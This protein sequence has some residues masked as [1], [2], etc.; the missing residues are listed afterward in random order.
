MSISGTINTTMTL[1]DTIHSLTANIKGGAGKLSFQDYYPEPLKLNSLGLQLSADVTGKSL[2]I[3]S[4]DILFGQ[5]ASPLKLHLTATAQMLENAVAVKLETGLQQ[6]KVNE[7]DHYWP[8]GIARGARKWLVTN[9][10]AGTVNNTTLNLDMLVPTGPET[11][12]Q[13]RKLKGTVVYSDLGVNY[14]GA[15]PP[16]TGVTGSGTF[17]QRGFDLDVNKGLVNGVRIE[18]GKVLISGMDNKKAAILVKTHLNGQLAAVFAVLEKPPIALSSD[19]I[20]GLVSDQLGGQI[21]SDFSISLPLKSGLADGDIKYQASGKITDGTFNKIFRDYDLQAANFDFSVDQSKV[22]FKGPLKFSGI[23][24]T[25]DWTTSLGGPGAGHADFTINA[26]NIT[27]P[28]ISSLG[29]DVNKYMQGSIALKTTAKVAPGGLVTASVE[30]DLNNAALSV[31]QI[32]WDKSVDDG[33]NID[34][35]LKVEKNHFHAT[36]IN[37]ELGNLKTSGN[38][39]FDIAGSVMSLSLEHLSLSYAQLNGLKLERDENKNLKFTLQG[40]EASLEPFLSGS[41][42]VIGPQKKQVAVKTE[43]LARQ[44]ESRGITFEIGNSKLDKVYLNKD[45]YFDNVQFSGRRD[46]RGWQEINLSGHN[47]FV[48]NKDDASAQPE[49]T[50][51]L[52]SEQF[53]FVYGPPENGRYRIHIEAEDLGS[54][55]SAAKGK[56]VMRGGYLMLDGDS[57][58]PFLTKPIQADFKLS[59]FTVKEAPAISSVLN[60]A[61]LSQIFSTFMQT[62]LAFNWASGDISLDGMR[63]S[64]KQLRMQGGSLGLLAK[65]WVDIKQQTLDLSGTVIPM[66]KINNIVG[67]IPLLGKAVVGKDGKGIFAVDYTM[68]GS[69]GQPKTSI[70]KESLTED[71][72]KD[73]LGSEEE[74]K[75]LNQQ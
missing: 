35:R 4:L 14:F 22:N 38:A 44:L 6:L 53:R 50:E 7:F 41:D 28:Q 15:L 20:T 33:G 8:K 66:S 61:S 46:S 25:L 68:T 17:D 23:P 9:L 24:L 12:F 58:G 57:Q 37:V 51:K 39:E 34:F 30:S 63:L 5:A 49:E 67:K 43:A 19:S 18:S 56:N 11:K 2:Q 59:G 60:M 74:S 27:S 70:Q 65:G 32:H 69:I 48:D 73:T 71:V 54:L 42:Q 45:T 26:P 13:L 75:I 55:V 21:V 47:P 40:G 1:P 72:L 64:S 62:G 16:A 52:K 10:N 29:Y 3:S 31:P 36:D